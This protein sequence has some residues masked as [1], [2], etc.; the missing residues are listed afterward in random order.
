MWRDIASN[1]ESESE[2]MINF[3]FL[4]DLISSSARLRAVSSAVY[5]ELSDGM[6]LLDSFVPFVN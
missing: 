5:T 2:K 4:E 1:A 3:F 6:R